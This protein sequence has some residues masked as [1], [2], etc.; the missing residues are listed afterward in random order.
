MRTAAGVAP[1]ASPIRKIA[2]P[3]A[4]G[5]GHGS[6]GGGQS[7]GAQSLNERIRIRGKLSTHAPPTLSSALRCVPSRAEP[8]RVIQR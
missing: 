8:R 6:G 7:V 5:P 3:A 1:L 2:S 4:E